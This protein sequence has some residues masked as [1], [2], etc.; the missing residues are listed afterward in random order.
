MTAG[1][2]LAFW[3]AVRRTDDPDYFAR[4]FSVG[5]FVSAYPLSVLHFP[6]AVGVA[7]LIRGSKLA[8][9]AGA[10]L[11]NPVTM[12]PIFAAGYGL[13]RVVLPH[14]AGP[15]DPSLPWYSGLGWWDVFA[16]FTGCSMLGLTA[17]V[18]SYYVVRGWVGRLIAVRHAR[19][20]RRL[21]QMR[22][23]AEELIP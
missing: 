7:F 22:Q 20:H 3:K 21:E 9:M 23:R 8:S 5:I 17:G 10:M 13:G 16:L 4:G 11:S 12:G 6:L 18:I 14:A 15:V 19:R 2:R 1:L